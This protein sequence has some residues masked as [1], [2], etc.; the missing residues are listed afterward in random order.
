MMQRR[1]FMATLAVAGLPVRAAFAQPAGAQVVALAKI[2]CGFPVGGTADA[3]ARRLAD[4]M[5]PG[6]AGTVL[7]ENKP[8]A[9][10][11]I[12]ITS[13]RDSAA[14]GSVLCVSPSSPL[15]MNRHTFKKLP[16]KPL[17]DAAS[18]SLLCDFDHALAVGPAVPASV[19]TVKD[20]LAWIK[21]GGATGYGTPGAAGIPHLVGVML[22]RQS[23]TDL[24]NVAYRGSAPA[25]QDLLGGQVPSVIAPVGEY[26]PYLETGK[27]RLLA[28]AGPSRSRFVPNVATLRESGFD[29]AVRDWFGVFMPPK[30]P[31]ELLARASAS[32][33]KAVDSAELKAAFARIAMEAAG[34]APAAL[35][36]RVAEEDAEWGRIVKAVGFTPEA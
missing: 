15:A 1:D 13:L 11:G 18:V 22:A 34:S 6:Y 19:T 5:R 8:G 16:Y 29:I 2:L 4:G 17:E 27:V 14:D 7:V 10:G 24:V 3:L 12:A 28:V 26:L 33:R 20:F 31:G 36:Q 23:G 30:T 35:A 21:A 32:V 9:G 25:L